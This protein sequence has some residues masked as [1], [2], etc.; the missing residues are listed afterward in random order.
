MIT[1]IVLLALGGRMPARTGKGSAMF[2]RIRGFRRLFDEGEEDIRARFAEQQ[3]IFSQY[4]PYAIVFGCTEKWARA[5]EGLDAEQL[6]TTGWYTGP[7]AF[8]AL[9]FSHAVDHFGTQRPARSTRA[10]RRRRRVRLS[11]AAA[12][13]AAA[14]VEAA[15]AAG[16]PA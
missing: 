8:S 11:A 9:A 13:P 14:A 6:G 12:S 3:G 4:L 7:Y 2:S 10:R 16:D 5:F 15:A 1:G